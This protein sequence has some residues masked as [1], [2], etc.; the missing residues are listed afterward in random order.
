MPRVSKRKQHLA[1]I[2]P[3]VLEG[4]KRRKDIRQ[5]EKDRAFRIRQR[6]EDDLW[7]EYK[8]DH[9]RDS[10]SGESNSDEE[11]EKVDSDKGHEERQA[12]VSLDY[13][14]FTKDREHSERNLL[15]LNRKT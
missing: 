12:Y 9:V 3:L 10:S 14:F 7:D 11:E 8:S 13:L 6:E 2:A 15:S 5:I 4:I 1:K